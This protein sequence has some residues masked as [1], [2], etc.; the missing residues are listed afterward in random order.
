[1]T[2]KEMDA[3]MVNRMFDKVQ[4]LKTENAQ[5]KEKLNGAEMRYKGSISAIS[6]VMEQLRKVKESHE[7]EKIKLEIILNGKKIYERNE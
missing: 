6:K 4:T 1:M 2:K 5:L 7:K 3:S